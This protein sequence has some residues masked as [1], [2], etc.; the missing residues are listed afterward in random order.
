[1]LLYS[2]VLNRWSA[3]ID[4]EIPDSVCG[5]RGIQYN[6]LRSA[7]LGRMPESVLARCSRG[8]SDKD[9]AL[10]FSFGRVIALLRCRIDAS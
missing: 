8:A 3:L 2:V 5:N 10:A 1:M 9:A 6:G 7:V 4:D